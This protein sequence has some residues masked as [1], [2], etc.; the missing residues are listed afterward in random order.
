MTRGHGLPQM[1]SKGSREL[2]QGAR[3]EAEDAL[4]GLPRRNRSSSRWEPLSQ[5]LRWGRL[6]LVAR[7]LW[8][9]HGKAER[10]FLLHFVILQLIPSSS[11][12]LY[13]SL[14]PPAHVSHSQQ[15]SGDQGVQQGTG[16]PR[17]EVAPT[18]TMIKDSW[19]S[20]TEPHLQA[21]SEAV[22]L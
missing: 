17:P 12:F 9:L 8:E 1:L 14:M 20:L 2:L 16:T 21:P 15:Q 5:S 10:G 22:P 6:S 4:H 13:P 19:Y 3:S 7:W 11:G 18:C